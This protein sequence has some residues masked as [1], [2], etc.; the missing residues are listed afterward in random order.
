VISAI[1]VIEITKVIQIE[2]IQPMESGSI[3]GPYSQNH[4]SLERPLRNGEGNVPCI[5][6]EREHVFGLRENYIFWRKVGKCGNAD[7]EIGFQMT[8][9]GEKE[10]FA[11]NP[12]GDKDRKAFVHEFDPVN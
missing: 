8:G 2:V 12:G 9:M 3:T 10:D 11:V 5:A 7:Q 6:S 1:L 4:R